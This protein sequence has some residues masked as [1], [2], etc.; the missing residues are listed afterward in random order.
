MSAAKWRAK[1][2]SGNSSRQEAGQVLQSN[3][4]AKFK[5]PL[6]SYILIESECISIMY[7]SI[8]AAFPKSGIAANMSKEI[9]DGPITS[10]GAGLLPLFNYQ[11]TS[12]IAMVVEQA[13]RKI[14]SGIFLLTYIEYMVLKTGLYG[15]L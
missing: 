4:S 7:P 12:R 14:S 1:V 15:Y 6:P 9:R 3:I 10:G 2:I 11:G 13:N 8:K 5:Y